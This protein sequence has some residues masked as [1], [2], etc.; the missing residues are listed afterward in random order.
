MSAEGIRLLLNEYVSH[1]LYLV[2]LRA[3]DKCPVHQ[4]WNTREGCERT[5]RSVDFATRV[6]AGKASVG[7]ALAYSGRV[8]VDL[9]DI[10]SARKWF[11]DHGIDL[12]ALITAP[13]AVRRESG[14]PN[15]TLLLYRVSAPL[16]T[17]KIP[18]AGIEFLCATSQGLTTQIVIPP[19]INPKSRQRYE[20]RGN[21]RDPPELPEALRAAWESVGAADVNP[22]RKATSPDE[23]EGIVG[24]I[25]RAYDPREE[26]PH[27][28]LAPDLYATMCEN[29]EPQ[30]GGGFA[31]LKAVSGRKDGGKILPDGSLQIF[32]ATWPGAA[33]GGSA[34]VFDVTREACFGHLDAPE[35]RRLPPY[36]RPSHAAI[37]EALRDEPAVRADWVAQEFPP[38]P[39]EP[40][41]ADTAGNAAVSDEVLRKVPEPQHVCTDLANAKRL[42]WAFGKKLRSVAG[43]FYWYTGTHWAR[44]L[45]NEAARCAANLSKIVSTEADKARAEA[46]E[47]YDKWQAAIAAD[48]SRKKAAEEHPRKYALEKM[49]EHQPFAE[50][51]KLAEALKSWS[52]TCEMKHCQ[53]AALAELKCLL[54]LDPQKLD[55]DPWLL[56][57]KSGT[58]DLRT[59]EIR[60]HHPA[61]FITRCAPVAFDPDAKAPAF[62]RFIRDIV[63][64]DEHVVRFL[65]RWFGYAC[66]GSTREHHIVIHWGAGRNGKGTLIEL[67]HTILGEYAGTAPQHLLADTGRGFERHPSEVMELMGKRLVTAHESDEGAVLREGFLKQATGGDRLKGRFMH[68]DFIEFP[69]THKLQLLTNHKP[70]VKGQDYAIWNRILLVR[71]PRKHGSATDI[72]EGRA[73]HLLDVTLPDKLRA[74]HEGILAWLVRGALEWYRAGLQPPD[75]VRKASR[76]YQ[77]EQDRVG[78]FVTE[79]CVLVANARTVLNG[80]GVWSASL[81]DAYTS[82]CRQR[83]FTWLASGRFKQELLDR[84]GIRYCE[85][86]EGGAGT[87]RK[88]RKTMRGLAGIRLR[89]DDD[90]GEDNAGEPGPAAS[91]DPQCESVQRPPGPLAEEREPAAQQQVAPTRT[92]APRGNGHDT[93]DWSSSEGEADFPAPKVEAPMPSAQTTTTV[94]VEQLR[95]PS[96]WKER[97]RAAGCDTAQSVERASDA[98]LMAATWLTNGGT[99]QALRD[100]ARRAQREAQGA[101]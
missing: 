67:L 54:T 90:D 19:S 72:T 88:G 91:S 47:A 22:E 42:E 65:Q 58:L 7:L 75:A 55:R 61:D 57:C 35:D 52:K 87:N 24:A 98:K 53:D 6:A 93:N 14:R 59:G 96:K 80:D 86:K 15:R 29:F 21:W 3:A 40:A 9:D 66:T 23:K 17:R 27:S 50:L 60:P 100:E 97:L 68:K 26:F 62:E 76:E 4:G 34:N 38:L 48:P 5:T 16:R 31:Y 71:Y 77:S 73:T 1:G 10:E 49:P 69:P 2:E 45:N 63:N 18:E 12:G 46:E 81:Y 11:A 85:W 43:T 95:I 101:P 41:A 20:W 51:T 83:G 56:N 37:V 25:C 44:D 94:A 30:V 33:D 36:K 39:D 89:T 92:E 13:D 78:Q 64:G 74:E 32:N 82:W 99:L 8:A 70:L 28:A 79:C 84:P